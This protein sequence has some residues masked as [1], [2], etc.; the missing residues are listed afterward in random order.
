MKIP[1]LFLFALPVLGHTQADSARPTLPVDTAVAAMPVKKTKPFHFVTNVPNDLGKTSVQP[2]S[3]KNLKT[4][5]ILGAASAVLILSDQAIYDGVRNFSDHI[6][7]QP[8]ESNKILLSIKSGEKETVLLK[9]PKNLNTAFY[10]LGQGFTSLLL[11]GGL[12]IDG[13]LAK[14]PASLQTASDL[15]ES[16]IA[17]GVSTQ[18]LK[19]A[20]GRETPSDATQRNGAFRPFPSYSDFQNNKPKYDAFPSGHL[21]T[22]MAT[23]TI[24]ADNYPNKKWIRPVGYSLMGLSAFSMVNNGVHWAGDYPL[25]I[26]IGYLTAKIITQRHQIF[27]KQPKPIINIKNKV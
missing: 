13:V 26:G 10:T 17:L 23:I 4:T 1:F 19:Y 2:F 22:L 6:H 25:A 11:A 21:S 9:V 20:T 12:A 18:L 5:V 24:L 3:K 16:F 7:L 8:D 15:T 14:R 27:V